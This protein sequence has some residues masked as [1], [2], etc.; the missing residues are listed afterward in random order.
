MRTFQADDPAWVFHSVNRLCQL[1]HNIDAALGASARGTES[2][3]FCGRKVTRAAAR[4]RALVRRFQRR[5]G[6]SPSLAWSA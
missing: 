2:C 4:A 3:Y 1:R 6:V 5:I